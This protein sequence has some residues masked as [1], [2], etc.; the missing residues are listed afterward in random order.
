MVKWFAAKHGC[1]YFEEKEFPGHIYCSVSYLLTQVHGTQLGRLGLGV[2]HDV[3]H[4][5]DGLRHAEICGAAALLKLGLERRP[6]PLEK[7]RNV[8]G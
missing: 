3:E 7:E 2:H 5:A 6:C 4:G 8:Q 1:H